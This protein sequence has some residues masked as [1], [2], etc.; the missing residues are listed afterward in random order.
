MINRRHLSLFAI[1]ST[2]GA[3]T[4]ARA[5]TSWDMPTPYTDGTFHTQNI[6]WFIEEIAKGTGND[7]KIQV[8]SNNSLIRLPE[9]LRAVSSGQVAAGEIFLSQFGNEDPLFEVDA[10][11]FLTADVGQ[12]KALYLS[13][14][15]AVEEAL[16]R[17]GIRL[18]YSVAWPS[19]AF[20]SKT[21]ITSAADMR[22][23]KFRTQSPMTSRMAEL[24]GAIPTSV[25]GS[26]IPQAF[27]TNIVTGMVT[28]SPTGVQSRAWEFSSH[29][30]DLKAFMPKNAVIV[31]E[32]AWQR[33]SVS[34]REVITAK[35]AAAEL[36]GW[37][38]SLKSEVDS[39]AELRR[40]GMTIVDPPPA[41]QA[42]TRGVGTKIAEEWSVRA[43]TAGQ[44]VIAAFRARP[45]L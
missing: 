8:H 17:R 19:Q 37:E 22:G 7:V 12:A 41:L 24:L 42:D 23:M 2:L 14:K 44:A 18:L 25:Q 26:E 28:S 43:G 11:P 39:F 29:V 3:P 1:G 9:I 5:Q 34:A 13:S 20:F 35:A 45:S 36:R 4:L 40:N 31:N 16:R 33:L 6:R 15:T 21:P 10:I 32:R 38:M 30:V 27:A